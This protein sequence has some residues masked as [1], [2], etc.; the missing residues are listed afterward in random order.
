MVTPLL[1]YP[2]ALHGGGAYLATLL[3][4]LAELVDLRLLSL[5]RPP[6]RSHVL[7]LVPPMA[8]AEGVAHRWNRDMN[9][10]ARLGNRLRLAGS[11]LT[12]GLPLT[13]AKF[14][15]P[16]LLRRLSALLQEYRPDAVLLEFAVCAQ[17]LPA[18]R[19]SR[20]I[21]TDHEAAGYSGPWQRFAKRFYPQ[22]TR[23][24]AVT[25][26]DAAT[27]QDLLER[28]VGV[29]PIVVPIPDQPLRPAAAPARIGFIGSYLHPPNLRSALYLAWELLPRLRNLMPEAVLSLAGD[30]APPEIRVLDEIPG[31]D[32]VGRVPSEREFLSGL[33]CLVAP[34][35][36]GQGGRVKV[37]TA[38]AH[39]LPVLTNRLGARGLGDAPAQALVVREEAAELATA[40]A[41][42]LREPARAAAAGA[43]ARRWAERHIDPR[44]VARQQAELVAALL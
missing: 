41:E 2:G 36:S 12:R 6:E 37:L 31:I 42:L 25:S 10:L 9:A 28:S 11:M 15:S 18:C 5:V 17:Y 20:T 38:L 39:G 4:P 16:A 22:A 24:Q 30:G 14:R 43:E 7:D 21:L 13:V 29:R 1:P 44:A 34:V 32:F 35:F 23:L 40:A 19:H 3:G 26:E 27:L 8:G 33:R